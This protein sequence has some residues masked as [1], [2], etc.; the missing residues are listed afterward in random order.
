MKT[1]IYL[2]INKEPGIVVHPGHGNY[3]GTL[4][5]RYSISPKG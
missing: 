2:V 1:Q 3:S 4:I 5:K